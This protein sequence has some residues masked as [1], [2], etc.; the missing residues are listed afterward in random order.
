MKVKIK[1]V[2]ILVLALLLPLFG[3]TV[4]GQNAE[5]IRIGGA[6]DMAYLTLLLDEWAAKDPNVPLVSMSVLTD[7]IT[8]LKQG[9]YDAV[10]VGRELTSA[11][12]E[13]ITDY[14]IAYDAVCIVVDEN[15]YLGGSKDNI[16]LSPT[17]EQY[18]YPSVKFTGL[19]GLSTDDV[20]NMFTGGLQWTGEYYESKPG[21]DPGS[22][23]WQ[24]EGGKYA[25]VQT[26]RQ[27]SSAFSFQVGKFDT[28]TVLFQ[29]LGLDENQFISKLNALSSTRYKLEEEVIS[30]EYSNS[31]YSQEYGIQDFLFHVAF[32][33]RRAMTMAP[34][35]SPVRVLSIDGIDPLTNP[36]SVY[37]GSY[38]FSRQIHLLVKNDAPANVKALG[39]LLTSLAGQQFMA[40]S[41][42][43]PLP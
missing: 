2:T 3:C 35:H 22:V 13:G 36:A 21:I 32:A 39:E 42:Y 26:L 27:L 33:S 40:D 38:P 7:G 25:W 30:Y 15:T 28:Q 18:I 23:L 24:I 29:T 12:L 19:K 14:I 8:E 34:Q 43:L 31:T 37:D 9:K 10:L 5:G 16:F 1:I 4:Q 20:K 17:G 41:G 6:G 11:E